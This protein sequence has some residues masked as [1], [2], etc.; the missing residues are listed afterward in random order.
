MNK[1][2]LAAKI[3][4][5]ANEMRSK[6]EANEYKDYILG[7]IFYKFLSELEVKTAKEND[8]TDDDLE[9]LQEED[10][11]IV[12]FFQ[13]RIG[14]FIS[15]DN[16]YSTWLKN[17]KN[18]GIKNVNEALSAF[19]RLISPTHKKVFE[20]IFD[21]LQSG[22]TKLGATDG[23]RTKAI[24]KLL[25]LIRDIPM[26]GR[27]GYD[28][29][30]FIYEYLISQFAANAGKKAGEFYTPHEV[31]L[32]MSEIIAYRLKDRE[33]IQIYDP[34]S[35]SGSLLINIGKAISKHIE[36]QGNIK[37][38]AQ[39]LKQNT[40][41]LTRMNLIMRG[42]IPANIVARNGDT[43]EADWPYF[44]ED[45]P[46]STYDPLF[47]DAV[48]S[49]PPYSQKW[50]PVEQGS[51]PR[52]DYGIAPKGKA[53]YAFLL[54]DLYHLRPDGVMA[55]VLPHGVLFRGEVEDGSEGTIRRNLIENNN[56]D[57]II[58][59][60]A[61]IFFGTG[62]PTL[63]L[64]LRKQ[65]ET[66]DVL[67]IDAS[68][69]FVKEGKKNKLRQCDIKKIVDTYIARRDVPKYARVVSKAEISANGYNLNI[70]R[71][72]NSS[73]DP[74]IWDMYST[75]F[76]GMPKAEIALLDDYWEALKGV[77]ETLFANT[78]TPYTR[79]A[80]DDVRSA[81]ASH[82]SV[83]QFAD[84]FSGQFGS[85]GEYLHC[86]LIEG[87]LSLSIVKEESS[88]SDEIF[89][90][91]DKLPLIDRYA[92]YQ[93]FADK[94]NTISQDLEMIQ[95]EGF[96]ATRQVDANMV[97]KKSN[98]KDAD[99]TEVKEVQDGWVGHILPF[100]LVQRHCLTEQ[101]ETLQN[102]IQRL[103]EVGTLIDDKLN[104][105]DEEEREAITN[106]DGTAFA[107]KEL[108]AKVIEVLDD[109]VTPEI[110]ALREYLTLSK[111]KD[112]LG[113]IVS[114]SEVDWSPMPK[115]KNGSVNAAPI[116]DRIVQL[117]KQFQF[118]EDS[119]EARLLE[120]E[121]LLNEEKSLKS[122]IKIDAAVLHEQTKETIENDLT[123]E[124]IYELLSLKWIAPV[125]EELNKLPDAV[126]DTLESKLTALHN[127]Y[128]TTLVDVENDIKE[129]SSQLALMIDD[130]TANEF[131][132]QALNEFKSVLCNG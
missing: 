127:K 129:A 111:A 125:C 34:T 21:T 18:L 19:T 97:E 95:T 73:D 13:S 8:F 6:I 53:D 14:Y 69:G 83:R 4:A 107:L 28:V 90:R 32:L 128:A 30:G 51:D 3:W 11:E 92:A 70:P 65:R 66:N 41:N 44:E 29:L 48:V 118:P 126:I 40:Y 131:D 15:Y 62:I 132:L 121:R 116:K 105:F 12:D 68:K 120:T 87:M 88:I 50:T 123:D 130:L 45:N 27:Q 119:Y 114:H 104:E 71:Y 52:F 31:S 85:F 86:E 46:E 67:I 24:T 58:G 59:L 74:E 16:L 112:K 57:A 35:G 89:K 17:S 64:I 43:L 124:Q 38:Y 94:W 93:L 37:Y 75:M 1:Q 5:S 61:D 80:V 77:R 84:L 60:P 82:P 36:Q 10:S 33:R 76:G 25:Y 72:V 79:F 54:H 103:A 122:Q 22:L 9:S 42:I 108:T 101:Y 7:F 109:V 49:N 81:I 2:Q 115:A 98:K 110:K 55:I 117:Q 39:E 96:E 63:V 91:I 99:N 106:D 100:D 26:D 102:K 20:K 56:I 78:D 113:F 23:E 47:V